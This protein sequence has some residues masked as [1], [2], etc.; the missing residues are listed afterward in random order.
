MHILILG[1]T[2]RVG[3][4]ILAAALS[5]SHTVTALVRN[6]SSLPGQTGLTIIEGTPLKESDILRA[7]TSSPAPIDVVITALNNPR[8]TGSPFAASVGPADFMEN[9]VRNLVSVMKSQGIG[10]VVVLSAFG[11]G[12]SSENVIAPMRMILKH[13][14]VSVGHRDHARVEQLLREAK[15]LE[16]TVVKPAMLTEGEGK[17]VREFGEVGAGIGWMPKVSMEGVASFMVECA[18]REGRGA[19]VV[20]VAE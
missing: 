8:K 5:Q 3:S 13:S 6:P 12:S 19:R 18:E 1:A 20:V 11:V 4:R 15:G 14:N 16:W 7:I 10:R 9:C 2:G 17:G